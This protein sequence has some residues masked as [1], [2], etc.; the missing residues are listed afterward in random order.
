MLLDRIA[1]E[2]KDNSRAPIQSVIHASNERFRPI[3]LTTFTTSLGLIPL[4]IGGGDMWRPMAI[5][6]IFG[7]L[8]ATIITLVFVPVMYKILFRIKK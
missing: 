8:F 2:L 7:L 5:G 6:I 1:I 4:W 3:L